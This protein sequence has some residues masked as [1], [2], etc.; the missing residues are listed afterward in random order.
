MKLKSSLAGEDKFLE[1]GSS[2][3]ATSSTKGMNVDDL[4]QIED[5][6]LCCIDGVW[7]KWT[8]DRLESEENKETYRELR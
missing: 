8:I 6:E 7:V 3:M 1:Q 5:P 4:N 2:D